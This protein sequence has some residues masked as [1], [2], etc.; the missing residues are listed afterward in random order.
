MSTIANGLG[1]VIVGKL[2]NGRVEGMHLESSEG[3]I[4]RIQSAVDTGRYVEVLAATV[5]ERRRVEV[6]E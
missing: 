6:S 1:V 4:V 2:P 3:A 5:F